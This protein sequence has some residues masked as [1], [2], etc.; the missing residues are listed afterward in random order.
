MSA[1]ASL[2]LLEC[3][4]GMF[5]YFIYSVSSLLQHNHHLT[6][7]RPVAGHYLGYSN[8]KQVTVATGEFLF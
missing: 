8:I 3:S 1:M 7:E 4:G 2:L 6:H 5:D